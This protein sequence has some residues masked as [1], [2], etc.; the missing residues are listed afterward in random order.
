MGN[1]RDYYAEVRSLLE[2]WAEVHPEGK[3]GIEADV[4]D[5]IHNLEME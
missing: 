1:E 2:D 5:I 4:E 3:D